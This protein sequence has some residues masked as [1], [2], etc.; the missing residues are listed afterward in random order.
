[1]GTLQFETPSGPC[2][3]ILLEKLE[4][5]VSASLP[6]EYRQFLLRVDGG[7]PNKRLYPFVLR[8]RPSVGGVRQFFCLHDDKN[9]NIF[10]EIEQY[11]DRV[12]KSLLPIACDD[13]GNLTCI[14]I[15][16]RERGKVFFWDHDW[17]AE[18]GDEPWFENIWFVADN[19][20][21][22]LEILYSEK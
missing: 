17:E 15:S 20:D 14:G 3:P 2:D 19:F 13:G 5:K 10:D 9:W 11:R 6:T 8:G 4:S 12:P 18:R 16:A 7:R 22:F 1:M 21:T